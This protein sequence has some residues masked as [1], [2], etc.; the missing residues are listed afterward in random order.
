[1]IIPT[2][3]LELWTAIVITV[4]TRT[5]RR[6]SL[7]SWAWNLVKKAINA[8]SPLKGASPAFMVTNPKKSIPNPSKAS[9]HRCHFFDAKKNLNN[10]PT[11]MAGRA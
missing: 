10:T 8:G 3:A 2:V 6:I 4:P 5:Q 7:R 1:M 11:A 9:P